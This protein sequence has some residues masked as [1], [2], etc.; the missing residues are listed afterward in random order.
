MIA[1]EQAT[2]HC[3]YAGH[4]MAVDM[5][6]MNA[7]GSALPALKRMRNSGRNTLCGSNAQ[8]LPWI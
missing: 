1:W 5:V 6:V 2:G 7:G 3:Q 4:A 8:W